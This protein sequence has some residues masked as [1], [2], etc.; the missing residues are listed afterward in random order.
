MKRN[1]K[2]VRNNN[3]YGGFKRSKNH[4]Q[5]NLFHQFRGSINN[6][7]NYNSLNSQISAQLNQMNIANNQ[8]MQEREQ[9][10]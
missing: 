4:K 1:F 7:K 2:S 3:N 6:N 8:L 9:L 10:K 5:T